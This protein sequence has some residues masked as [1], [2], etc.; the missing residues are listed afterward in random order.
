M[1][2]VITAFLFGSS[3]L[4]STVVFLIFRMWLAHKR[5]NNTKSHTCYCRIHK[6][7]EV[8]QSSFIP[9]SVEH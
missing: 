6:Q 2:V 3:S 4:H 9:I 1:A 8:I 5:N 7:A